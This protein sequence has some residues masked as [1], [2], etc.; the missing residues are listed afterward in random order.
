MMVIRI[1]VAHVFVVLVRYVILSTSRLIQNFVY[2]DTLIIVE[3]KPTESRVASSI[4]ISNPQAAHERHIC[5][6]ELHPHGS[7]NRTTTCMHLPLEPYIKYDLGY[8]KG[9]MERERENTSGSRY[10]WHSTLKF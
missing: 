3:Y 6:P 5:P 8:R 10:R 2:N 7:S 1:Q 9:E 4:A